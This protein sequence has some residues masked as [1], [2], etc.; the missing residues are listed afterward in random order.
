M[1]L[2]K[3]SFPENRKSPSTAHGKRQKQRRC[4][5]QIV[6]DWLYEFGDQRYDGYGGVLLYFSKSSRKEMERRYGR[7]FIASNSRLLIHYM[8]LS[9]HDGALITAGKRYKRIMVH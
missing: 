9:S 1:V 6:E 2:H 4:I 8:V 5:P 3:N 7:R